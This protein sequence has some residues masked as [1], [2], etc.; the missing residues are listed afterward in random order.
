MR[1]QDYAHGIRTPNVPHRELRVVSANSAYPDYDR[2]DDS[3][4]TMQ[5]DEARPPVNAV[6]LA[7]CCCDTTINGLANLADHNKVIFRTGSE[8]AEEGLPWM[9]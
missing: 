4:Q 6:R 3:T 8:C 2:V 7:S 5:V 1:I 9:R